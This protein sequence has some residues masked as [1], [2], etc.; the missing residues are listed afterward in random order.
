MHCHIRLGVIQHSKGQSAFGRLAYQACAKFNDGINH[1]DYSSFLEFHLGTAILLPPDA[2]PKFADQANFVLAAGLRKERRDGQAGRTIDFSLPRQLPTEY[3]LPVAAFAVARFAQQGMA[4][5]IDVECPPASDGKLNPHVHVYLAQRSLDANGFGNKCRAWN[6]QFL[7]DNGRDVRAIIAGRITLA[8]ALLG[9][10]ASVDP[11]RNDERGL[12]PA[13]ER[14][15]AGAW[16]MHDRMMTAPAVIENLK[17]RRKTASSSKAA[18]PVPKG[19]PE[20]SGIVINS[21]VRHHTGE[22]QRLERINLAMDQA[23]RLGASVQRL[24]LPD[25]CE[26]CSSVPSAG[27]IVFDGEAI[28]AEGKLRQDQAELIVQLACQL[29][30]PALVIEGDTV[31]ADRIIVAGVALRLTAVNRCASDDALSM[32]HERYGRLL[33]DEVRPLDPLSA[34]TAARKTLAEENAGISSSEALEPKS[35]SSSVEIDLFDMPEPLLVRDEE[36]LRRNAQLVDEYFAKQRKELDD[37]QGR[38]SQRSD[39]YDRS[40]SISE[41][42]LRR[43]SSS[44]SI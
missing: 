19:E 44:Q 34:V 12:Q 26:I 43:Q 14:I 1:A 33:H 32:V 28:R 3:L 7:R 31:S 41:P 13:E 21:A 20:G 37:L 38:I 40:E 15:S 39:G 4:L 29:K 35:R 10:A 30:W 6:A 23:R 2:P 16:R 17:R 11:R 42:D 24:T 25:R 8:C 27:V 36:A 22:S 9:I 5:R 18:V